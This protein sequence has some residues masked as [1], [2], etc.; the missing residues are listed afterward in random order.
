MTN[1]DKK[2]RIAFINVRSYYFQNMIHGNGDEVIPFSIIRKYWS[3]AA[4]RAVTYVDR[5]NWMKPATMQVWYDPSRE[6]S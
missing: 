6:S 5:G 4:D 1:N 3:I 2:A